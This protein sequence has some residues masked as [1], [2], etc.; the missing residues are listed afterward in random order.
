MGLIV[1]AGRIER[2]QRSGD[3]A[4][5]GGPMAARV[6]AE[7]I[8]SKETYRMPRRFPSGGDER[9]YGQSEPADIAFEIT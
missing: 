1:A 7:K 8:H 5:Q 4:P 3:R 9:L 6:N 2:L